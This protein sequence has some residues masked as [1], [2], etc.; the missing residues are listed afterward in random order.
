MTEKPKRTEDWIQIETPE[1]TMMIAS[2]GYILKL[3]GL[4]DVEDRIRKLELRVGELEGPGRQEALL[5][6]LKSLE[7]PRTY[8]FIEKHGPYFGFPDLMSLEAK[9]LVVRS[10]SGHHLLYAV[11]SE[12][13]EA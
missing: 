13:A 7:V 2:P 9:G 4:R 5:T 1:G 3:L 6:Y 8:D 12:V 11:P 10:R